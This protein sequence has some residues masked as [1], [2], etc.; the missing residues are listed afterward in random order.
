M[1]LKVG[2][3]CSYRGLEVSPR[4]GKEKAQAAFSFGKVIKDKL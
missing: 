4:G 2:L 3:Q 1:R